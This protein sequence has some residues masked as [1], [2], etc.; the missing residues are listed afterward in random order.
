M[1]A[2]GAGR[3]DTPILVEPLQPEALVTVTV[4]V[5]ACRTVIE[6]VVAP[7]DHA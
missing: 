3:S 6:G 2:V 4:Y 7:F 5:P 1:T